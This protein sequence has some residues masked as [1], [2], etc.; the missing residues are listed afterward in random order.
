MGLVLISR[1]L[2]AS[3]TKDSETIPE[4]E[5]SHL[6]PIFVDYEDPPDDFFQP[7]PLLH[8]TIPNEELGAPPLF[9]SL[10]APA[11]GRGLSFNYG[12]DESEDDEETGRLFFLQRR[13]VTVLVTK[14]STSTSITTCTLSTTACAGRRRRSSRKE[15]VKDGEP[16][17]NLGAV[18]TTTQP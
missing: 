9:D 6:P 1:N 2:L 17:E 8:H 4:G 5:L 11:A 15:V 18:P 10:D 13:R 7:R 16:F 14:T 3:E 12:Y